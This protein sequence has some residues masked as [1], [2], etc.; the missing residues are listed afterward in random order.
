VKELSLHIL[1][2]S[3]NSISAGATCM[4][5]TLEWTGAQLLLTITDNGCGMDA[6]LC[7]QVMDPFTTT[8]TTRKVGLGLP[9]LKLTAE[10]TGGWVRL[11]SKPGVGTRLTAQFDTDQID[12]PPLGD[13]SDTV[14]LLIQGAPAMHLIFRCRKDGE[15]FQLDTSELQEILGDVPLD[16]P[17]VLDWIRSYLAEGL[18]SLSI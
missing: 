12:C 10:Q 11:E 8:R 18:E 2:I 15:E 17:E 4:T 3:Q 13:L 14:T 1:D 5:L 9:L 7:E 16:A 6:Q